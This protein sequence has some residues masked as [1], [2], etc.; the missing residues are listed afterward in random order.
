MLIGYREEMEEEEEE[1]QR[2]RQRVERETDGA[3]IWKGKAPILP[4]SLLS[5]SLN[6]GKGIQ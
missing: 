1:G 3:K 5:H 6:S 2:Q 4:S